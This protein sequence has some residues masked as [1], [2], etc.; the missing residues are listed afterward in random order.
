ME[1]SIELTLQSVHGI[2]WNPLGK[3]ASSEVMP[4]KACVSFSGS[5][6][7]MKVSSFNMCPRTGNLVVESNDLV[8]CDDDQTCSKMS[9]MFED[10]LEGK[11]SQRR[12]GSSH[13]ASTSSITS[14]SSYRPHLQ[15]QLLDPDHKNER[16]PEQE[17]K[18]QR[19]IDLLVTIRS[20]DTTNDIY[21][22]GI[23]HLVIGDKFDSLPIT[24]NLPISPI[25]LANPNAPSDTT[26]QSL[27][28]FDDTAYIRVRLS[29]PRSKNHF[30]S[31]DGSAHEQPEI[32]LSD[33]IDENE[34]GGM[35]RM[36]HEREEM[37][38]ARFRAVRLSFRGVEKSGEGNKRARHSNFFCN[39]GS[40]LKQSFRAFFDV[41]RGCDGGKMWKKTKC[42]DPDQ[43][44]FLN[45]T[46]ASTIDTR[47]SLEI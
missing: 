14:N 19:T 39:G 3:Y 35:M 41:I 2:V 13:S 21:Q 43:E 5:A 4:M 11:R 16:G 32:V 31:L 42:L 28:F 26:D 47:D 27:V 45:T 6:P 36:M 25:S 12:L 33:H 24:I 37:D 18:S 34:L 7:N 17:K 8:C 15:F 20:D 30:G 44:I 22:E 38:E 9:A 1:D 10:P 23:A 46:M 40:D 29:S